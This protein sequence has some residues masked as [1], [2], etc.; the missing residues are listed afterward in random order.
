[1]KNYNSSK[2]LP[3]LT[4][5]EQKI[6][7]KNIKKLDLYNNCVKNCMS[8]LGESNVPYVFAKDLKYNLQ[9]IQAIQLEKYTLNEINLTFNVLKELS[10]INI[11]NSGIKHFKKNQLINLTD[12][13]NYIYCYQNK[14]YVKSSDIISDYKKYNNESKDDEG[15]IVLDINLEDYNNI[16]SFKCQT[17]DIDKTKNICPS[18]YGKLCTKG[19]PYSS[20]DQKFNIDMAIIEILY[21][22]KSYIKL[23]QLINEAMERWGV[24]KG[25][26][27]KIIDNLINKKL[28]N[29]EYAGLE[30]TT[31]KPIIR[32]TELGMA[33][34]F[35]FNDIN[36]I[37]KEG[38]ITK[39]K[40]KKNEWRLIT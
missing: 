3:K 15:N 35:I 23:R 31:Q 16:S 2:T 10:I 8:L 4:D 34:Y 37:D 33:L 11:Q 6:F 14:I 22:A 9:T 13:G 25:T 1:M 24:D 7:E 18:L 36:W 20:Q 28:I 12:I 27:L 5:A 39:H 30:F 21:E 38:K 17:I 40:F 19:N 29:L 26:T 32:L